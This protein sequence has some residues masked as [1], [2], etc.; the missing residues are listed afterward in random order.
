MYDEVQIYLKRG[1]IHEYPYFIQETS[2]VWAL[3]KNKGCQV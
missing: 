3:D 2:G 1:L